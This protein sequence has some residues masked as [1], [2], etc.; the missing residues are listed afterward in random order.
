MLDDSKVLYVWIR[1]GDFLIR[2]EAGLRLI[3]QHDY[4]RGFGTRGREG[5]YWDGYYDRGML[6]GGL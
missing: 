1:G 3:S 2:A 5:S 6:D 4:G